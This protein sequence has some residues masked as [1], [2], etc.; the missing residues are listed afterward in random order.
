MLKFSM[1]G[2]GFWCRRVMKFSVRLD[3]SNTWDRVW[4]DPLTAQKPEGGSAVHVSATTSR[5]VV[6][7]VKSHK[8][9]KFVRVCLIIRIPQDFL[10]FKV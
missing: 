9:A 4:T 5:F 7:T 10:I 8:V 6:H 1:R 3:G 2:F